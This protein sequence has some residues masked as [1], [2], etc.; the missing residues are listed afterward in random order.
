MKGWAPRL[1]LRKRLK[2]I[3]KWPIGQERL[4]KIA[5]LISWDSNLKFSIRIF[6]ELWLNYNLSLN[7]RRFRRYKHYPFAVEKLQNRTTF[8]MKFVFNNG[9]IE[10]SNRLA[11]FGIRQNRRWLFLITKSVWSL[12]IGE[13][14]SLPLRGK[15]LTKLWCCVGGKYNKII[16]F[17][18]LGW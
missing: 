3:R 1:A 18:Q 14:E 11:I 16:W 10:N 13:R 17:H 8:S 15:F 4:T 2:V 7:Q 12:V 5:F 6:E 9:F